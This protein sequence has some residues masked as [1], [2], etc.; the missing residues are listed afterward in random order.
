MVFYLMC[1]YFSVI[2][3]IDG[4]NSIKNTG[5]LCEFFI[6][7][8]GYLRVKKFNGRTVVLL[9]LIEFNIYVF[10]LEQTNNSLT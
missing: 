5:R 2:V 7:W 4:A 6:M 8:A 9:L 3:V 1:R 10:Y